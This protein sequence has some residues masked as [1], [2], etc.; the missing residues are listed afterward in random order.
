MEQDPDQVQVLQQ[1]R[2]LE[3]KLQQM[4]HRMEQDGVHDQLH[5]ATGSDSTV[6]QAGHVLDVPDLDTMTCNTPNVP[7]T[8][9][10]NQDNM[11]VA[12]SSSAVPTRPTPLEL[13]AQSASH[14]SGWRQVLWNFKF[15]TQ[16]AVELVAFVVAFILP[17]VIS[18]QDYAQLSGFNS[19]SFLLSIRFLFALTI[20][21]IIGAVFAYGLPPQAPSQGGCLFS[22]CALLAMVPRIR[23]GEFIYYYALLQLISVLISYRISRL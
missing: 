19:T 18:P 15:W 23:G 6:T 21:F 3:Y 10:P 20:P 12:G 22:Y 16:V 5:S 17:V 11:P 9:S 2:R 1:R 8:A 7:D 4:L 14:H 13:E